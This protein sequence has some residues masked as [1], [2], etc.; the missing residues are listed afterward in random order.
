M[1]LTNVTYLGNPHFA[2][3]RSYWRAIAVGYGPGAS[4]T[5]SGNVVHVH[6]NFTGG[7][8]DTYLMLD[9]RFTP[10]S[11][12]RWTLDHIF[13]EQVSYLSGDPTPQYFH[14]NVGYGPE[15]GS[16]KWCATMAYDGG[17]DYY[18]AYLPDAPSGYWLPEVP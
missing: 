15:P 18:F 1:S 5:R 7:F 10:W 16:G 3:P 4:I 6:Q 12:N 13:L 2:A 8:I 14:A 9:S 11:S 17:T